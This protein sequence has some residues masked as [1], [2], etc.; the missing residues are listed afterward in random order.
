M[1]IKEQL[2]QEIEQAPDALLET[3]LDFLRLHVR[4]DSRV[5][6]EKQVMDHDIQKHLLE[7]VGDV[8]VIKSQG[9]QNFNSVVND[10]REERII[11]L[12]GL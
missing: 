10:M 3:L 11:E 2:L 9:I 7:L 4:I 12:G 5:T 1:T 8:V 6:Q